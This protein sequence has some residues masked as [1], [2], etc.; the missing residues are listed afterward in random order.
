MKFRYWHGIVLAVWVLVSVSIFYRNY[1]ITEGRKAFERLSCQSCHLAGGAPSL[2]HVG[3]KY[4][5]KTFVD[6]I[7]DPDAVYARLGRKP[8]NPGYPAM[9]RPKASHHEIEMLSYFLA[10]QHQ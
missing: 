3:D 7:S 5:R 8:L 2:E 4:D 6:F 10:A 1:Q 9:P